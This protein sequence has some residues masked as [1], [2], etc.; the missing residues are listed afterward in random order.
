MMATKGSDRE[1]LRT[2]R[3]YI[4]KVISEKGGRISVCEIKDF[5]QE[6]GL[7]VSEETIKDDV[8]GLVNTG[9]NI[10]TEEDTFVWRD[11][12]HD[13]ILP[14]PKQLAKSDL[15]ERKEQIRES[16][17]HLSHEYLSLMD[18]AYDP[19]QNRL[20]EMKVMESF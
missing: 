2:R 9:L 15:S 19:K 18:L 6:C 8:N 14:L 16:L 5:L 13:F 17:T 7:E 1:Y 4:L 3:T 20:F 10:S 11:K 12:L